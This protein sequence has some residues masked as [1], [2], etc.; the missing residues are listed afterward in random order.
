MNI[1]SYPNN[2]KSVA[3]TVWK[4]Q[5]GGHLSDDELAEAIGGLKFI[6]D[7]C[8]QLGLTPMVVY[9]AQ[10]K[11]SLEKIVFARKNH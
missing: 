2:G 1:Y 8:A 7:F 10:L 3:E 9:Y 5:M 4:Y 6:V 11:E